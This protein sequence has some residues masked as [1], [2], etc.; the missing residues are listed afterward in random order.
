VNQ[1]SFHRRPLA[2]HLSGIGSALASNPRRTVVV[3]GVGLLL[4]WLVVTR[5]L[6]YAIAEASPEAALWLNPQLPRALLALADR[7]R[8]KLVAG[9][10]KAAASRPSS[11]ER[12]AASV[13]APLSEAE[14]AKLEER[15]ALRSRIRDLASRA[16]V[17]APLN[18]RAV[19][20]IAEVTDDKERVRTLMDQAVRRSRRESAATFWLMNDSIERGDFVDVVYRGDILLRTRPQLAR[21]VMEYFGRVADNEQARRRLVAMLTAGPKWR[22]TFFNTMPKTVQ[23]DEAFLNLLVDLKDAGS[24][25]SPQEL[26]PFIDG[27]VAKQRIE[28]AYNAWLQLLPHDQFTSMALVHG[29]GFTENPSGLPFEWSVNRGQNTMVDFVSLA[30]GKRERALR[31]RFGTGRAVFPEADQ[32]LMLPPGDYRLEGAFQG[33]LAA[34]R[35]LKWELRCRGGK[36]PLGETEML[37]G[38]PKAWQ[39]FAVELTV[40]DQEDCRAQTLRVY[41]PT[42]S[43]SEQ[44]ISGEIAFRGVRLARIKPP[45]GDTR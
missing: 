39:N 37:Y 40:P 19:R 18:A 45:A 30:P 12:R 6:S 44:L 41:H 11:P 25:P 24:P 15:S 2:S 28:M 14:E 9:H 38:S 22:G 5:S 31:Y 27:L 8:E 43:A 13:V 16:L 33:L 23:D 32:I 34:K 36:T 17:H 10:A 1:R 35:G 20:L 29:E 26:E 42:R 7:E 3:S 4:L 21:N